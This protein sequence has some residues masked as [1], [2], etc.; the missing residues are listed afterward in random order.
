MEEREIMPQPGTHDP[1]DLIWI[2]DVA[3]DP[4]FTRPGRPPIKPR[5]LSD[6]IDA[7]NLK[8]YEWPPERKIYVS[9]AELRAL[10]APRVRDDR[11]APPPA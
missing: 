6:Q 2:G 8:R 4:E 5:W 1:D 7:G 10:L 3:T 11:A 9:R